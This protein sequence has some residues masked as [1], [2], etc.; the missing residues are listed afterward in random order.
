MNHPSPRQDLLGVAL[1]RSE[2]RRFLARTEQVTRQAGM[3]PQRYDLLLMVES[4]GPAGVRVTDLCELLQMKQ[5]AV[6]ELVNRAVAS[7]LLKRRG[8][9][10]DGRVRVLT[11][12]A[13]G[14]RQLLE[15][16]DALRDDRAALGERFEQL[17]VRFHASS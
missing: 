5:P 9:A 17:G 8:S 3:T 10:D 15:V 6:T 13:V 4:A 1:F 16:F 11:L 2:L 14:R 7:K 12:T